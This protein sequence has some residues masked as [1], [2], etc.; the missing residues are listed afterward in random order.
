MLQIES[1]PGAAINAQILNVA[2]VRDV[3]EQYRVINFLLHGKCIKKIVSQESVLFCVIEL[4]YF[5][6]Y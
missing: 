4:K 5:P 3:I 1:E 2:V 6:I